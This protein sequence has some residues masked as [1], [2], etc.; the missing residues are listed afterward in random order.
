M[1]LIFTLKKIILKAF[2]TNFRLKHYK[3]INMFTHLKLFKLT[4]QL[5]KIII[6]F[7]F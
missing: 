2:I 5:Y 4:I 7:V 6:C 3:F 1:F